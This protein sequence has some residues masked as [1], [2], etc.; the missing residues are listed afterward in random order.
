MMSLRPLIM[1]VFYFM[2]IFK[3]IP[4]CE[5]H[6]QV[7]DQGRVKSLK[8]GKERVLNPTITRNGYE[9]VIL[10]IQG[11]RRTKLVHQLVAMTFLGHKPGEDGFDVD[12]KDNIKTDNRASELQLITRRENSS[13]DRWR[14][15]PSSKYT[16]V[17][18]HKRDRK[19]MSQIIINKKNIRLGS[20]SSEDEAG[21]MYIKAL[22]S[23]KK[24]TAISVKKRK[25]SSKY[26]GVT[27]IESR[28]KW[29]SYVRVNKKNKFLGHFNTE[30]E[31]HE[32]Y[33]EALKK[34]NKKS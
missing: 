1:G 32:A 18:W 2:E 19:W 25:P 27:W 28:N 9:K 20:F 12:H 6:Y 8:F 33:Q 10:S 15:N 4:E 3:D 24:G 5:G 30:L 14:K 26:K 17:F 34:I 23:I 16:G 13:K 21:E 11:K 31:A 29:L 22:E 7:S